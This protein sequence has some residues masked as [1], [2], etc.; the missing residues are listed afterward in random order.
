MAR[1]QTALQVLFA[2]V[3]G[4]VVSFT[5]STPSLE[6]LRLLVLMTQ[7]RSESKNV[8]VCS[9]PLLWN[10]LVPHLQI[11]RAYVCTSAQ[12]SHRTSQIPI[13]A[14]HF[15]VSCQTPLFVVP[16]RC[17]FGK[18]NRT[19]QQMCISETAPP[20]CCSTLLPTG[21]LLCLLHHCVHF[22]FCQLLS[23]L[24]VSLPP[25]LPPSLPQVLPPC[26]G[27]LVDWCPKRHLTESTIERMPFLNAEHA[28]SVIHIWFAPLFPAASLLLPTHIAHL[29]HSNTQP[30]PEEHQFIVELRSFTLA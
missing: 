15:H 24:H 25:S 27:Q 21:A 23:L 5:T 28:F 30:N 6:G 7:F 14:V 26:D 20:H 1:C 2:M 16:G 19:Q 13:Y 17:R 3:V 18:Q 4:C 29:W 12:A 9:F 11:F 8:A 22:F 10:R